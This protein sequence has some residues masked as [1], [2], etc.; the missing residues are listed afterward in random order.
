MTR[1]DLLTIGEFSRM[2]FLSVK[3][4]RHYHETGL[5]EPARI[6]PS[7]GYRFYDVTQVATAQVIRRFRDL[8]LPIERLRELLEAPDDGSRNA[9]IVDHLN[10]MSAQ[11]QETR[12]T[13]ESL[14]RMLG[15]DGRSFPV[16]YRHEPETTALA[17]AER[18]A[19]AEVVAWWMGAFTDLHRALRVTRSQR[20]GADG[21]LFPT[22]Y[23]TDETGDLV[24]FVPVASVPARLP[25]RVTA[26]QLPASRL[27]V[28]TYD[29]PLLD[30]DRAYGALGRW[31][32]DQASASE[33]PIRERYFPLG[34]EDDLLAHSTEVC[35][36][37][38]G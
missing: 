23:F 22:E 18:V 17:I 36:P 7:S 21:A 25:A 11:L 1:G 35:W 9:L 30:L 26:Y 38:T 29:G 28:T 6:D 2:T 5:L 31:V 27:A 3:T 12:E 34:D 24:A 37:V 13:V 10:R 16:S 4:L 15:E 19:G 14:K 33:G 32:H 20:T 8:D